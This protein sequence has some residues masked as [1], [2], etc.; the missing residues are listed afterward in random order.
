MSF[1]A[2]P[3][4]RSVRLARSPLCNTHKSAK[5]RHGDPQQRG[6]TLAELQPYLKLVRAHIRRNSKNSV[7]Q[8]LDD[9]WRLL[10]DECERELEERRDRPSVAYDREAKEQ[11]VKL[12][13]GVKPRDAVEVMLAMY[14][15]QEFEPR[16]F[17]S[18]DAFRFQLVRRLRAL[19]DLNV[20]SY[21]QHETRKVKRVYQDLSPR[22]TRALAG[23]LTETFGRAGLHRYA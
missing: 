2:V 12:K 18:D 22:T 16:R 5:R 3:G 23:Y 7:W 6:T 1:C 19:S 17:K 11:L 20:G 10:L 21:Y 9:L 4:C 8:Q 13:M 14:A 15:L